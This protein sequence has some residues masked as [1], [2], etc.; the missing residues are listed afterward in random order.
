MP[1]IIV[2]NGS[3]WQELG[4]KTHNDSW[5]HEIKAGNKDKGWGLRMKTRDK[6]WE[7]RHEMR[8]GNEDEGW[9]WRGLKSWVRKKGLMIRNRDGGLEMEDILN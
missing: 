2:K 5:G 3:K 4:M 6:D 7:W 1:S 8:V 9:E